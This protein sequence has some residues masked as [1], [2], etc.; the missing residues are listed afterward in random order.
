MS[1]E[2]VEL[3]LIGEI[4]TG[5]TPSKGDKDNFGGEVLFITPTELDKD[6]YVDKSKQTLTNKGAKTCRLVPSNSVM[7]CCIGSLGKVGI[8]KR[9]AATNQQI[10][11]VIVNQ[12]IAEPL[13]VYFF[14]K[15]LKRT[16]E[17]MAPATTVAIVNKTR[18]SELKIPLPPLPI[19]KQIAAILEKADTLRQQCQ[20]MQTELNALAQSVFLEMFGDPVTNPKGWERKKLREFVADLQGGKSIAASEEQ[21]TTSKNRVLK[22]SAVTW[23]EFRPTESKPLP[24]TYEPPIEHFVRKNDLLFSRANTTELVGATSLVFDKHDN[25]LLPDKLWRFIWKDENQQSQIFIWQ[26]LSTRSVRTE[27]GKIATGSGGSMKNISK[28]KLY[29]FEVIFPPFEL[30]KSFEEYFSKLR[31]QLMENYFLQEHYDNLFNALMQKAF[32]GEL[33]PDAQ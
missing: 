3:K 17:D 13:Y 33:I 18:F 14:C 7:V 5:S 8:T 16:L 24:D 10:N 28:S 12:Q 32:N 31:K 15:T 27:L 11:S 2:M 26:M 20:Q 9:E 21:K 1:W 23:G 29:D 6:I 22:I 4:V 30:Q 19:Q 25:L